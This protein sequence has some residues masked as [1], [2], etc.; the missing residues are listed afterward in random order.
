M[1]GCSPYDELLDLYREISYLGG[2]VSLV[3]WD[4]ETYMP[5]GSSKGRSNVMQALTGTIHRM[6]TSERM[7]VLLGEAER[8]ELSD[9]ES[10][11]VREIGRK[12]ERMT[13][14][15]E[16]L[17]RELNRTTSLANDAWVR[18]KKNND[19]SGFLPYLERI[20]DLKIQAAEHIGYGKEPYDALLDEFEPGLAASRAAEIL[21]SLRE[22]LVPLVRRILDEGA[23]FKKLQGEFPIDVQRKYCLRTAADLGYDLNRGRLDISAHPFTTGSN[24]DV[25]I[26]TR[27]DEMDLTQGLFSTI[28]E[29]GHALYE[30]G[31]L[32]SNYDTPLAEAASY[33]VHES[34][35][36]FYENII[37]RSRQFWVPRWEGLRTSFSALKRMDIEDFHRA[38]NIVEPNLIRVEADEVTYNLHILVRFEI[39]RDL[40]NGNIETSEV[41][42]VWNDKYEKYLGRVPGTDTEGCL[43][44]IHWAHGYFGYFP[45][46]SIGNLISAQLYKSML[47]D[48]PDLM[49]RVEGGDLRGPLEWLRGRVHRYGKLHEVEDLIKVSTGGALDPDH[50]I[51]YLREKYSSLHGISL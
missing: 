9:E 16:E 37:G 34:Q 21:G 8:C 32:E 3:E 17:V 22:R 6:F 11:V 24:L 29:T 14:L 20:V 2:A 23:R 43:Q 25:R 35:S 1:S 19:T 18:A 12:Y 38:V 48:I 10:A 5:P 7:G 27:F 26:T 13:A 44:D 45:S 4:R 33:G 46:Y 51:D 39:E 40:L 42:L 36:R 50:F 41:P 15:P 28:H 49:E 47:R 31:F 30:Q